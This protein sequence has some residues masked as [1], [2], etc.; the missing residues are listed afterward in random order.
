MQKKFSVFSKK[1]IVLCKVNSS[2]IAVL[3]FALAF[4]LIGHLK[5]FVR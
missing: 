5:H 1:K 3:E 4:V 2:L